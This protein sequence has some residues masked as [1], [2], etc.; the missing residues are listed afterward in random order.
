MRNSNR[1]KMSNCHTD[2]LQRRIAELK[3]Q[4]A[5]ATTVTF[6]EIVQLGQTEE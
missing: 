3:K 6:P 5:E 4:L 2:T 1:P